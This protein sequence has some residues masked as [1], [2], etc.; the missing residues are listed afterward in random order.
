MRRR[1]PNPVGIIV[2]KWGLLGPIEAGKHKP[3]SEEVERLTTF[4]LFFSG[5]LGLGFSGD[6]GLA[7]FGDSEEEEEE[8]ERLTTFLLGLDESGEGSSSG[9]G[10]DF[11]DSEEK[12]KPL[13]TFLL[14]FG[15]VLTFFGG[16][17]AFLAGA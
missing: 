13:T 5:D 3:P 11:G 8:V 10:R 12:T 4:L 2:A 16:D 14:G 1:C 9:V 6:L 7:F 17:V 15:E